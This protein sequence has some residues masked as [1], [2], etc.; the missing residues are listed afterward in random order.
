[1]A[2][3]RE[4]PTTLKVQFDEDG[5]AEL[6]L[7]SHVISGATETTPKDAC[8]GASTLSKF[9]L[10]NSYM[11]GDVSVSVL[12]ADGSDIGAK[13]NSIVIDGKT[14]TPVAA[15]CLKG[16]QA[17]TGT[18]VSLQCES[19][20]S[21]PP[22]RLAA[23]QNRSNRWEA[24]I[25]STSANILQHYP[26]LQCTDSQG[27]THSRILVDPTPNQVNNP[28]GTLLHLNPRA[29]SGVLSGYTSKTRAEVNGK[30]VMAKQHAT[31]LA[32]TLAKTLAWEHP[33]T[34]AGGIKFAVSGGKDCAG[35]KGTLVGKFHV[36][37]VGQ[38]AAGTE[39]NGNSGNDAKTPEAQA[40]QVSKV[41][42][43]TVVGVSKPVNFQISHSTEQAAPVAAPEAVVSALGDAKE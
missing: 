33:I 13:G 41:F 19:V 17:H 38:D 25:G 20:T 27:K 30:V 11:P 23:I 1:M 34:T 42:S 4:V 39:Q 9:E 32:D 26:E 18:H 22:A 5:K 16:V 14:A 15:H 36:T 24:H 28:F 43:A 37:D 10:T 35:K 29:E 2:P 7:T 3:T 40:E 12:G 31:Q 6:N 21:M 8:V